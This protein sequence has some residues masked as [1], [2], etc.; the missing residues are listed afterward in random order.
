MDSTA[1]AWKTTEEQFTSYNASPV[2]KSEWDSFPETKRPVTS[3]S[4]NVN[5]S[6]PHISH[7]HIPRRDASLAERLEYVLQCAHNVGF[8][9]FDSMMSKYYTTDFEHNSGISNEQCLSRNRRLPGVLAELRK[10]S[11]NWTMWER[12]GYLQEILKTAQDI[13]VAEIGNFQDTAF[14][15]GDSSDTP[16]MIH[17]EEL[18]S[19]NIIP[20]SI[21]EMIRVFQNN[22]CPMETL[23]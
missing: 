19:K 7:H 8:E 15:S 16:G 17:F 20:E 13:Y 11:K 23:L 14:E 6:I 22:V 21:P 9:N 12:Q 4:G 3:N 10:H 1:P 2:L 5:D 18:V